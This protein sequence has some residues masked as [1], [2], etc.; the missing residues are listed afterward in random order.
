MCDFHPEWL[1]LPVYSK[2]SS[3]A[4]KDFNLN[5]GKGEL[6]II[7]DV[8]QTERDIWD[9]EERIERRFDGVRIRL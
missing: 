1:S 6:R 4:L 7:Q 5:C 2:P 8:K 3:F 9:Q